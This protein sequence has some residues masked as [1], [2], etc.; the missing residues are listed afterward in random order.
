MNTSKKIPV[1]LL[2][3]TIVTTNGLYL[4]D[5]IEIKEAKEYINKLGF[6]S[7]IGHSATAEIMSEILNIKIPMNRIEFLQQV[8]QIAIVFKLNHR[9]PEGIV[10]NKEE[11]LKIGYTLKVMKRLK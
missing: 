1:V 4:I 11:I 8:N 2:N 5:D 9:P 7:A 10:L 3:G 6:I